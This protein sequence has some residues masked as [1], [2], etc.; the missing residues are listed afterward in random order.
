MRLGFFTMPLHPIGKDWRQSLAED[1]EAFILADELGFVEAYCGEHYTDPEENIT[2]S[3]MFIATL[4]HATR[5]IRLGT[6]TVNMPNHHP[7]MTASVL[8]MLDHLL[9]G[10]LIFGIS[11]GALPS[12]AEVL[13]NYDNDRSAMFREAIEHVLALWQN[14]PPYTLH[15]RFWNS[16]TERTLIRET[17]LGTVP[18]PLQC[19]HPPI[20]VTAVSPH[21]NGVAEA[22]ARGWGPISANFIMPVWVKTHWAKYVEGCGRVGRPAQPA[23]WRVAKT[24]FVAD[25]DATARA[26]ATDPNSPYRYYY[27]SLM[28]KLRRRGALGIFKSDPAMPDSEVTL[29]MVCD[30]LVI[31]GSPRR[32][33]DQLLAFQDEVGHFGTLLYAGMD[34]RDRDLARR[35][36]ILLAEQVRPLLGSDV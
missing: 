16:S 6:G 36:M 7:A 5:T 8:A 30:K 32:V 29:D 10:R 11:P 3:A 22:G 33:A 34:W 20:V 35:S 25:D 4:A 9:D 17:G 31:H 18:K 27:N 1:R 24:V 2:S 19:P 21:S 23:N 13:G 14:D 15:G 28:A 12:D 26:Y